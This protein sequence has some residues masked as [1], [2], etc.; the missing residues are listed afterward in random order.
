MMNIKNKLIWI[1]ISLAVITGLVIQFNTNKVEPDQD[2]RITLTN[3]DLDPKK[4]DK[5]H[6]QLQKRAKQ[7]EPK[8]KSAVTRGAINSADANL[9]RRVGQ[10]LRL[11]DPNERRAELEDVVAWIIDDNRMDLALELIAGMGSVVDTRFFLEALISELMD[12]DP[13][14]AAIWLNRFSE[15]WDNYSQTDFADT[16][17]PIIMAMSEINMDARFDLVNQVNNAENREKI[18]TKATQLLIKKDI[19]K[20]ADW[21]EHFS[22]GEHRTNTLFKLGFQWSQLDTASAAQWIQG[23]PEDEGKDKAIEGMVNIWTSR[24]PHSAANWAMQLQDPYT[25]DIAVSNIIDAWTY[26]DPQL[27][28]EWVRT[29]PPGELRTDFFQRTIELWSQY[30][31]EAAKEWLE[32]IDDEELQREGLNIIGQ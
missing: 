23:L 7:N 16:I 20:A 8:A 27:V 24:D 18:L 2:Q 22:P 25:R 26:R 6:S 5:N 17:T 13:N 31:P 15:N 29:F 1:F 30:H 10:A 21:A 28:S 9:K 4:V 19:R 3:Q 32:S 14:K 12:Q 11:Q